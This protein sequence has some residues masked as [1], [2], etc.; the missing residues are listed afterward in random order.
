MQIKEGFILRSLKDEHVVLGEGL[1]Q[2]NFDSIVTLNNSATYL[3]ENVQGK[4]F[5][6]LEL[7]TL[8]TEK[9]DVNMETALADA[10]RW[11]EKLK[12]K[13]IIIN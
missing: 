1:A 7:A 9:Y 10:A 6:T 13:G 11:V 5:T 12:A 2:V 3:W 4:E 8:L